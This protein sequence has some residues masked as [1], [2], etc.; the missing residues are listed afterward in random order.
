MKRLI[1][2]PAEIRF[3]IYELVALDWHPRMRYPRPYSSRYLGEPVSVAR[4]NQKPMFASIRHYSPERMVEEERIRR[5]NEREFDQRG[6]MMDFFKPSEYRSLEDFIDALWKFEGRGRAIDQ[7]Y[8]HF[9]QD[10]KKAKERSL[11][12]LEDFVDWLW[13]EIV[14]DVSCI[15][16][17]EFDGEMC[18]LVS[19][20]AL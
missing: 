3:Q 19:R 16:V 15:E 13:G 12:V 2:L 5:D 11:K 18:P 6:G 4:R 10:P 14:L 1:K 7:W 20:I 17:A 8:D 9:T